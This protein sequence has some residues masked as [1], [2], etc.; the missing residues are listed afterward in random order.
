M[1]T[2]MM[3]CR[4]GIYRAPSYGIMFLAVFQLLSFPSLIASK[5]R[6]FEYDNKEVDDITIL[7]ENCDIDTYY[8]NHRDGDWGWNRIEIASLLLRSHRQIVPS[9]AS[10]EF[11]SKE[12]SVN[13]SAL[14]RQYATSTDTRKALAELDK[15]T[16]IRDDNVTIETVH[17]IFTNTDIPIEDG[18]IMGWEPGYIWPMN[19]VT[20]SLSIEEESYYKDEAIAAIHDL[21]NIRPRHP[22]VHYGHRTNNWYYDTCEDC[23]IDKSEITVEQ[24]W[25]GRASETRPEWDRINFE[26]KEVRLDGDNSVD[27]D[28]GS[29]HLCVCLQE[30]ALQPPEKARGEVARALLYMSLRYGTLTPDHA[31]QQRLNAAY[32]DLALTDCHPLIRND[33][34]DD[35]SVNQPAVNTIGYFSRLVQWHLEDPPSLREIYRNDDICQYYQGNRNPFV[36]FYEESWVLLDFDRIEREVCA[37]TNDDYED[38]YEDDYKDDYAAAT[39]E[40]A[41]NTTTTT[42]SNGFG[43]GELMQG[44][45]SFFMVQPSTDRNGNI[46]LSQIEEWQRESFGLVTLVNLE[47]GLVLYVVGVDDDVDETAA[48]GD[49]GWG[50]LKL[51]VPERGI[52]TGSYFGYGK[53]MYLGTQWEPILEA[54]EERSEFKFSVHQ[55]YLYCARKSDIIEDSAVKEEYKILAA[56]STTGRSFGND[57]LPSYWEKFQNRHSDIKLSEHFSDGIHYGLIVLPED[58]SNSQ[59]SGGYRYVGPTYTKHDLYAKALI[60][61][62]YWQRM[63]SLDGG[64]GIYESAE[65]PTNTDT[66]EV[67]ISEVQPRFDGST[68]ENNSSSGS[69]PRWIHNAKGCSLL[70]LRSTTFAAFI[71]P[72]AILS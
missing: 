52:P 32:L 33:D 68:I 72:F 41:S 44:D 23:N 69:A 45:I 19:A 26:G 24:R 70:L 21:H 37:G 59:I 30:H 60:N 71:L 40:T 56:L 67:D 31:A 5:E 29:D 49:G 48:E 53:R 15:G 27:D 11:L 38:D 4:S 9:E 65:D 46:D 62:A 22:I 20:D 63:N 54:G 51:E 34:Y 35:D 55:L 14:S 18:R 43:C 6:L 47:P 10:V 7:F 12:P 1:A 13:I 28:E 36:D 61:E 39:E 17:M 25:D 2:K 64:Q 58:A 42:E 16:H 3:S 57:G 66:N 50:T 8:K